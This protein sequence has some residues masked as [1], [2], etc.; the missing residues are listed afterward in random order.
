MSSTIM[1]LMI[2]STDYC[3]RYLE[4]R[5]HGGG[6]QTN[7]GGQQIKQLIPYHDN[8]YKL[9]LFK[10]RGYYNYGQHSEGLID[11]ARFFLPLLKRIPDL[12]RS[13][14]AKKFTGA[15]ATTGAATGLNILSEKLTNREKPFKQIVKEHGKKALVKVGEDA[16]EAYKEHQ[17]SGGLRK[18]LRGG[19]GRRG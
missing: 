10:G 13:P 1:T 8:K 6:G 5:M 11:I 15:V 3:H 4:R 12:I 2:P 9:N 18:R 16:L 19:A 7:Y 17:Q 14:A